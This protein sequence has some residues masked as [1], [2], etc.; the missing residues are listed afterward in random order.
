MHKNPV[1]LILVCALVC[2]P[3]LGRRYVTAVWLWLLVYGV[4]FA[5]ISAYYFI[6]RLKGEIKIAIPKAFYDP[7]STVEGL[8]E[9]VA[10]REMQGS[11]L[12]AAL[13]AEVFL[14]RGNNLEVFRTVQTFE[15]GKAYPSGYKASYNFRFTVPNQGEPAI[16]Q[17]LAKLNDPMPLVIWKVEVRLAAKGMD[18]SAEEYLSVK[19]VSWN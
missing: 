12:T 6:R 13:V 18:L 11:E 17:A 7:G 3:L 10:R 9:L 5:G 1:I 14:R 15:Q 8:F 16:R 4:V 19:N 2:M